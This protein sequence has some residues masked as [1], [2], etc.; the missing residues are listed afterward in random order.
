MADFVADPATVRGLS[1]PVRRALE[2]ML[3]NFAGRVSLADLST[4]TQRTPFQ[5]IRSFRRELG[6]TPHA[7]LIR[8]RIQRAT[9][10]LSLGE[11]IAAIAA[12]VGFVDQTH[13]SRHFKRIHSQ[14]PGRFRSAF[15]ASPRT[16]GDLDHR[17]VITRAPTPGRSPSR[18]RTAQSTDPLI[19]EAA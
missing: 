16:T 1:G 8:I 2:H 10:M 5:I 19:A 9:E 14:T 7:L 13:L 11:P 3:A 18:R 12:D 4:L 15:H 17:G 6:V